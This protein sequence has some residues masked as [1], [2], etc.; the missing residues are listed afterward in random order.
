MLTGRMGCFIFLGLVFVFI[1]FSFVAHSFSFCW[2]LDAEVAPSDTWG[3]ESDPTLW[4][5]P[6]PLNRFAA[7]ATD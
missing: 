5:S 1:S 4:A 3:E 2:S 6:C 7:E